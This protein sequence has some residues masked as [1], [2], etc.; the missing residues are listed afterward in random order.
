MLMLTQWVSQGKE[1]GDAESESARQLSELV[2]SL[3][4]E[5]EVGRVPENCV[6]TAHL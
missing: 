3:Q 1:V 2:A 6:F 5:K 4:A